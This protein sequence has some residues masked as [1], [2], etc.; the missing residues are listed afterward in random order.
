[1]ETREIEIINDKGYKLQGHLELPAD[2]APDHFALLAHCFTCNSNFNSVRT[3]STALTSHGIGV[4]RFDFTG[5]GKSQGTFTESH[6]ASNISDLLCVSRYMAENLSSPVLLIGHSLGGAAVIA[7]AAQLPDVKAVATIGTPFRVDHVQTHFRLDINK[8]DSVE[9]EVRIGGRP[10]IINR[11]FIEEMKKADLHTIL[12]SLHKAM[13][14][15]HAPGDN[16]VGI[17]NATSL[18][19]SALHPKSFLSLDDADHLLSEKKDAIYAANVIA[20][21]A[22]RYLLKKETI[23][24]LQ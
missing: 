3:I 18:Y 5:L 21:W 7:A 8:P 16:I 13:L 23:T 4:V 22:D 24:I 1:M 12:G 19:Q 2:K 11:L 14:F 10:Y 6:F 9:W 17:E 15:L 20:A